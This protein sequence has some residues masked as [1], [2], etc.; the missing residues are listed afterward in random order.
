MHY[1]GFGFAINP[2][3]PSINTNDEN[4]QDTI[5]QRVT[6]SFLDYA[7]VCDRRNGWEDF[8]SK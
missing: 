4:S 3:T 2:N 1:G 7:A 8:L 5:G 6:P